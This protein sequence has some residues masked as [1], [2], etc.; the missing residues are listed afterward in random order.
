MVS[1]MLTATAAWTNQSTATT[2]V[3]K[4]ANARVAWTHPQQV[5]DRCICDDLRTGFTV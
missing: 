2:A 4:A 1:V 5:P 3:A